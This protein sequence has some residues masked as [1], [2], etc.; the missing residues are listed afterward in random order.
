M[1]IGDRVAEVRPR[2]GQVD[3]EWDPPMTSLVRPRIAVDGGQVPVRMRW[4][5]P[6]GP[7]IFSGQADDG[8]RP[9]RSR[10]R[11]VRPSAVVWARRTASGSTVH[12]DPSTRA[13]R[14]GVTPGSG[15]SLR[16]L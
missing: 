10:P 9:T 16:G 8:D 1:G 14:T 2:V 6:S 7:S 13:E 4:I 3:R 5:R 12:E 15:T 11:A